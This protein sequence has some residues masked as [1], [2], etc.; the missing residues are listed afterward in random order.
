MP[1]PRGG[2]FADDDVG[3]AGPVASPQRGA[4]CARIDGAP[5][6][7]SV[8]ASDPHG[9]TRSLARTGQGEARGV[10][11]SV[12]AQRAV[13]ARRQSRM[14]ER[15]SPAGGG[16]IERRGGTVERVGRLAIRSDAS[17]QHARPGGRCSRDSPSCRCNCAMM[18][19]DPDVCSNGEPLHH[20]DWAFNN[21]S[22]SI[23]CCWV[24]S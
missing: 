15:C 14:V 4:G 6:S 7:A 17:L 19:P 20:P 24:F 16:W 21:L 11:L 8:R 12:D 22:G 2:S 23:R 13:C 1:C 5:A 9:P 10:Q 18:R 3:R